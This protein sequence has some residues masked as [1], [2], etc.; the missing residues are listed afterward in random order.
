MSKVE[1]LGVGVGFLAAVLGL[2]MLPPPA[3]SQTGP[4]IEVVP[5]QSHAGAVA[6]IAVTVDGTR[7]SQGTRRQAWPATG[8]ATLGQEGK[9][10]ARSPRG[11]AVLSADRA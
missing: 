8:P 3:L 4:K 6:S 10:G 11:R 1:R 9:E 5:G 7:I 2:L